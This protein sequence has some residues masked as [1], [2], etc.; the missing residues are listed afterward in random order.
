MYKISIP[1]INETFDER[2]LEEVKKAEASRVL[3]VPRGD[4]EDLEDVI[5]RAALLKK[6]A[7]MLRGAG[8]EPAIWVGNTIGHGGPLEGVKI[9]PTKAEYQPLVNLAGDVLPDT[10]CPFDEKFRKM[11]AEYVATLAKHSTIK[12]IFLDDDYRLSQHGKEFCCACELHMARIRELCGE[13]ISREELKKL[14]F[15]SK[16]NKYREAWL[17]AERESLELLAKDI[18]AEVDKVDED[19]CVSLCAAHS[20]WGVD[21]T[22]A[23]G[24]SKILAGKNKPVTRLHPAPYWATQSTMPLPTVFE[25]ARMFAQFGKNSGSELVA[26]G[27]VYPRPRYNIPSSHL[28]LFDAVMRADGTYDGTLKYMIDYCS[29]FEHERGY[30]KRHLRNLGVMKEISEIFD[31][32]ECV[33]VYTPADQKV[34]EYADFE[35][36]NAYRNNYPLPTAARVMAHLSMPS[37]YTDSSLCAAIFGENARFCDSDVIKKGAMLDAI[38]AKI[39][40][41]KGIDTGIRSEVEFISS[42]ASIVHDD[43]GK[44]IVNAKRSEGRFMRCTLDE[45]CEVLLTADVA[46]WGNVVLLY[47]YV[48]GDGQK[49]FVTTVDTMGLPNS[50]AVLRG[51]HIQRAYTE[52]YEWISGERLPAACDKNP[53]LYILTK[54]SA[55]GKKMAVGLFNCY[56]D[57][58]LDPVV[59]LDGEYSKIGFVGDTHGHIVGDK[60]YLDGDIPAFE[61]V[62]FEVE[63]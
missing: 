55:D 51:Y 32:K 18:R 43:K 29:P 30:V 38:A 23:T 63:K 50:S 53:D 36:G 24:I 8:I 49:F 45:N 27:D 20:V 60:V 5:K 48:N 37:T 56:A 15:E 46:G 41:D 10:Y 59:E 42:A 57:S 58:V 35:L 54:K 62:A 17:A 21:G 33:G 13:D 31:D 12:L 26:E 39:L 11:E 14:A 22:T 16:A 40:T 47:R 4:R 1:I 3:L 44:Y 28:E 52:A 19:V 34:M 6:N 9:L 2:Y 25:I 7:E 61:F